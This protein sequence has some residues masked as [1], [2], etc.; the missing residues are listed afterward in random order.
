MVCLQR[1]PSPVTAFEVPPEPMRL[2]AAIEP[3]VAMMCASRIVQDEAMGMMYTV[4]TSM[5]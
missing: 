2:E 1:D 3:A 5:G 4:T